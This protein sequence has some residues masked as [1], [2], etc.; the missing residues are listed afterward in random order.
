MTLYILLAIISTLSLLSLSVYLF[1]VWH[2]SSSTLYQLHHT[3]ESIYDRSINSRSRNYLHLVFLSL[4]AIGF[5]V[6]TYQGAYAM[7]HWLPHEWRLGGEYSARGYLAVIFTLF[8]GVSLMLFTSQACENKLYLDEAHVMNAG[9]RKILEWSEYSSSLEGLKEEFAE[10][11]NDL[12]QQPNMGLIPP[13]DLPAYRTRQIYKELI[14]LV[15][16]QQSKLSKAP[17]P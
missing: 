9:L 5:L 13:P 17:S 8:G 1:M 7:L 11:I 14:W 4:I 12:N 3:I 2:S 16:H 6:C 10:K 15:N